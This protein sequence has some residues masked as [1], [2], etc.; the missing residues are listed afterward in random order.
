SLGRVW[1]TSAL[2]ANPTRTVTGP[3]SE[4]LPIR[5]RRFPARSSST[6]SGTTVGS[7]TSSAYSMPPRTCVPLPA[8]MRLTAYFSVVHHQ[9]IP[10]LAVL[11]KGELRVSQ[12]TQSFRHR[13]RSTST[14]RHRTHR[15]V[16]PHNGGSSGSRHTSRSRR[17]TAAARGEHHRDRQRH[18]AERGGHHR[19]GPRHA[20]RPHGTHPSEP[21]RAVQG[22]LHDPVVPGAR[23]TAEQRLRLRYR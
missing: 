8:L 17:G 20:R 21:A 1:K 12:T 13:V 5:H 16:Q 2:E 3:S 6:S 7:D 11:L 23:G 18:G 9:A 4:T 22:V 14:R 19:R 10:S 15:D